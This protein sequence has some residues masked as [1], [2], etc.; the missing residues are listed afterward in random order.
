MLPRWIRER[1]SAAAL[2]VAF[3]L[4]M[5][6]VAAGCGGGGAETSTP[7]SPAPPASPAT[8]STA[9]SSSSATGQAGEREGGS[10]GGGEKSIEGFGEEASGGE[11]AAIVGAFEGYL[12]A[13]AAGEPAA[14]C[15]YLSATVQGSLERFASRS[16]KRKGCAAILPGL[17]APTA[18]AISREQANGEIIRVRIEG[19][20]AFVIFHAPGAKLYEMP[21]V[22]ESG[23]WKTGLVAAAVLV[24]Q[25]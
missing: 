25:L 10:A 15:S 6:L 4:A 12:N 5:A 8:G 22:R 11:R 18:A 1:R 21:M 13:M 19:D 9:E 17:L 24:P 3:V 7:A 2:P 23:G 16:L 20:R 14:A